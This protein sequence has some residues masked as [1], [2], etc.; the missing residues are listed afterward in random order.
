MTRRAFLAAAPLLAQ[1]GTR[2][3]ILVFM[4]DQETALLPGP[5]ALPNRARIANGAAAFSHAFCNTPQCSPARSSLLTGLEPHHTGVRTNVDGGSIG[6]SL[7]SKTPNIG[8]VFRNA[9]WATG[10]FGKWRAP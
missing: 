3:N 5:A 10:Y 9:G 6:A 1:P 7:D 8:S 4:T 2:P